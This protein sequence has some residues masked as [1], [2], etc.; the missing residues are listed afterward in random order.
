MSG[1]SW[2]YFYSRL[3]EVSSRL[4]CDDDPVRKEFGKL[5]SSCV[6]PLRVIEWVDSGDS[7][8]GYE[9]AEIQAVLKRRT[10]DIQILNSI[11]KIKEFSN[12]LSGLI[13]ATKL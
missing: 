6:E 8:P 10:E 1:G 2:D 5:L 13:A 3:D 12:R 4:I 11:S 7:P 9:H